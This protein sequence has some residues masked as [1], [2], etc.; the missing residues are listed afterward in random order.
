MSSTPDG[1]RRRQVTH[2]SADTMLLSASFS[3]DGTRFVYSQT[4]TTGE[5]DIFTARVDGSHVRQVTRT[6][7]WDSAPDWGPKR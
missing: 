2:V 7:L 4:G 6:A 5:P 1:S 3:P